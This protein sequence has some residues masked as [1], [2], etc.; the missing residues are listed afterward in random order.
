MESQSAVT[1]AAIRVPIEEAHQFGVI[2]AGPDNKIA[3][4][5]EKPSDPAPV[6]DDPSSVLVSMGN[7]IFNRSALEDVIRTDADQ[8]G[9][10]HDV[11]GDLIPALV[12]DGAADYYDFTTNLVP[13][14]E[15]DPSYWR[16]VGTISSYYDAHMDLVAPI[17]P[18][19]L[20]NSLWPVHSYSRP[21]PP[22]RLSRVADALPEVSDS[23]IGRGVIIN[24]GVVHNSVV[25]PGAVIN[26][27]A[28]VEDSVIMD[29]VIVEAG[30]VVR[31]AILDKNVH[32]K[33]GARLGVDLA[34]DSER[35]PVSD[36]RIVTVPKKGVVD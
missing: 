20:Y 28:V 29:D 19:N 12:R 15:S 4:F 16:D 31:N 11:G 14:A 23:L 9:S 30:A 34:G 18:F 5:R 35:F 1:V 24:G 36:D 8:D 13:G 32:V 6:P 17:P 7:Y 26:A 33:E 21:L 22:A 10:R 3:S 2:E 27:G 25:S